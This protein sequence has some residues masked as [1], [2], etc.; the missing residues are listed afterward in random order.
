MKQSLVRENNMFLMDQICK[1]VRCSDILEKI[2]NL[3]LYINILR[4]NDIVTSDGRWIQ[5]WAMYAPLPSDSN[6]K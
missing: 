5:E 6:L 2:N 3:Q 1:T 4:L